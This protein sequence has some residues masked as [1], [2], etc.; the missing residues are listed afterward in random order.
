MIKKVNVE[1]RRVKGMTRKIWFDMIGNDIRSEG[2]WFVPQGM[3]KILK[4]GGIK[5]GWLTLI[6]LS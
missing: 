4:S 5:Q 3:W 1:G 6:N 2:C